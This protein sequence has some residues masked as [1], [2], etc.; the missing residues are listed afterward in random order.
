MA[1]P[2]IA[3]RESPAL[4][5]AACLDSFTQ[6]LRARNCSPKTVSAYSDDLRIFRTDAGKDLIEVESADVYRVVE[7]WQAQDV[8]PATVQ[9]RACAV[10]GFY[11]HLYTVGLISVRPTAQLRVPK[12]WRQIAAPA[13]EEL[14][15]AILAIRGESPFDLRDRAILLL[16]RDSAIRANAIAT[17][18]LGNVDWQLGRIMLRSDKFGKDHWVP[19]SKRSI[20]ALTL[21][22]NKGRPRFLQGRNLPYLF[23]GYGDRPL[24]RQRIWQIAVKW[25]MKALGQ[26]HSPHAWRQTAVTEGAEKG[27]EL[28]DLMQMVGHLNPETTQRYILHS[29]S[30][31]REVFNRTHPRSR[32]GKA[33]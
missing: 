23:V 17:S 20:A 22:V 24:T 14:E 26:R 30:K 33:Q 6:N 21:Y 1:Q 12:P 16:L 15:L 8:A 13:V 9:R 32:K 18:E 28:F 19:L 31:L 29:T 11:D 2:K 7:R 25:T 10:R 5:D 4:R 3:H 27:M